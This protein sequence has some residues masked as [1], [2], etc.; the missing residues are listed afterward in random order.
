MVPGLPTLFKQA[1]LSLRISCSKPETRPE[2]LFCHVVGA[3]ARGQE[4]LR[5]GKSHP[6]KI[7]IFVS[8]Q[9]TRH[10]LFTAGKCRGIEQDQ[11][12]SAPSPFQPSHLLK[13]IRRSIEAPILHLV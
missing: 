5:L 8:S 10:S 9:G 12:I 7:H 11:I 2:F 13:R 3:G 1:E 6:K 4:S